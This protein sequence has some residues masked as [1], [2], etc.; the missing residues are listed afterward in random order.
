MQLA[1]MYCPDIA[2]VSA[3][4]KLKLWISLSPGLPDRLKS[5]GYDS[6]TR[7]FT[8]AQVQAIIDAIGEP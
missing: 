1:Q 5:L 6:H 4:K 3:W 2:P 7:S 8:P